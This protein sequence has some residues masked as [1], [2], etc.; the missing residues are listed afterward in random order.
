MKT[1]FDKLKPN[2]YLYTNNI[3]TLMAFSF[4]RNIIKPLNSQI[5]NVKSYNRENSKYKLDAK[6]SKE[7]IMH[8]KTAIPNFIQ[9]ELEDNSYQKMNKLLNYNFS[10]QKVLKHGKKMLI[11]KKPFQKKPKKVS[12][13]KAIRERK[14]AEFEQRKFE[15]LSKSDKKLLYNKNYSMNRHN[16]EFID[17]EKKKLSFD[18]TQIKQARKELLASTFN[19]ENFKSQFVQ[20]D[21][22]SKHL[23]KLG[24]CSRRY[25]EKLVEK[26]LIKVNGKIAHSNLPVTIHSNIEIFTK[27][28]YR[29]PVNESA[30]IWV[31][32]KPIGYVC[33]QNDIR[34]NILFILLLKIRI[35]HRFLNFSKI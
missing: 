4:S 3:N 17:L 31:F 32:Y 11:Y 28:G 23:A 20:E 13:I 8:N 29:T 2:I 19:I 5:S 18:L 25:A 21:R 30:K 15:L 22:L 1:L 6:L 35:D 24:F 26:G 9:K 16:L 14:N 34:V 12:I 27:N 7:E 10:S 33:T